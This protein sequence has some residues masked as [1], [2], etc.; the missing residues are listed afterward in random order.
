MQCYDISEHPYLLC[1]YKEVTNNLACVLASGGAKS[2]ARTIADGREPGH[3]TRDRSRRCG[4]AETI[5]S[6]SG[7]GA[8]SDAGSVGKDHSLRAMR[9]QDEQVPA[10]H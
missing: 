4:T 2:N 3:A 9:E 5:P 6:S 10:K 1:G 8:G 7:P